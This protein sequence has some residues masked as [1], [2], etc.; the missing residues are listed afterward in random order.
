MTA[1]RFRVNNAKCALGERG[2]KWWLEAD[3]CGLQMRILM[4][5]CAL[6]QHR[7]E[8]SVCPSEVARI[9][10]GGQWR[11]HM[12]AVRELAQRLAIHG[13][14]DITQKGQSV[15]PPYTGPIRVRRGAQF[16]AMTRE[17]LQAT[18]AE[19]RH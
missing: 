2:Y 14:A 6:L 16:L 5:F 17:S 10:T 19:C 13:I 11:S 9:A 12:S 3:A 18:A 4:T 8:G 15:R 7:V 1:A